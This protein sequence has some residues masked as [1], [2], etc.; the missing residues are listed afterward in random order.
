[1]LAIRAH[2]QT[3]AS[4]Q[5]VSEICLVSILL[6]L[7]HPHHQETFWS[8]FM[9]KASI[10]KMYGLERKRQLVRMVRRKF[11][12]W[13]WGM[14]GVMAGPAAATTKEIAAFCF[15]GRIKSERA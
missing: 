14:V 7:N 8:S 5:F 3:P 10:K 2:K 4:L 15:M 11:P 1:M 13:L 6:L 12:V 9:G